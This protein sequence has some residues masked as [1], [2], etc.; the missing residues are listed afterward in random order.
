[1]QC[2]GVTNA[3]NRC[4]NKANYTVDICRAS[5][6]VCKK[7]QN[8]RM[9]SKWEKELYRRITSGDGS[10]YTQPPVDVQK[11]IDRFHEG[12]QNTQNIYVSANFATALYKE[13]ISESI[14]FNRKHKVYVN[15]KLSGLSKDTCGICLED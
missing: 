4:T 11:W 12:W 9:L 3:H 1:M 5:F 6:P 15:S 14:N 13:N 8:I 7:H 2:S 10:M